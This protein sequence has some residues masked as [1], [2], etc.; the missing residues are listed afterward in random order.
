MNSRSRYYAITC[1]SL[2]QVSAPNS[3]IIDE[4][5]NIISQQAPSPAFQVEVNPDQVMEIRSLQA[6]RMSL[7]LGVPNG[8]EDPGVPPG[9]KSTIT[10]RKNGTDHKYYVPDSLAALAEASPDDV[11]AIRSDEMSGAFKLMLAVAMTRPEIIEL[12]NL[13]NAVII[14]VFNP[15]APHCG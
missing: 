14:A 11:A 6:S 2:S 10:V 7:L 12:P 5:G 4:D 1:L 8:E 13:P 3:P 9:A 15:F